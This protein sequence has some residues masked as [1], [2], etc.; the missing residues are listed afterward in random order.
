MERNETITTCA[1][2]LALLLFFGFTAVHVRGCLQNE[3]DNKRRVELQ[4]LCMGKD[5]LVCKAMVGQ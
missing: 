4:C 1:I 5:P 3:N 2:T